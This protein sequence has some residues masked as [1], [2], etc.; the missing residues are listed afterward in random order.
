M[1]P[2]QCFSRKDREPQWGKTLD[3]EA[4]RRDGNEIPVQLSLSAIH[5]KGAWHAVG[6][7]RDITERK[8]AEDALRESEERYRVVFEKSI[9]GIL[10]VDLEMMKF[11]YANT[12]ICQ[13][14]GYS[15]TELL[16]MSIEDLHPADVLDHVKTEF[17]LLRH[18][19]K[20]LSSGLPCLRKDG[21]F[22]YADVT[23]VAAIINGRECIVGFLRRR[24]Q[25]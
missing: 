9:N 23:A 10:E 6:I 22:F 13:M 8:R 18:G 24:N 5:M 4:I 19:E 3:L 16:L 15:E 11:T 1:P 25:A 14:F 2:S 12:S 17:E 21:T 7:I 20:T